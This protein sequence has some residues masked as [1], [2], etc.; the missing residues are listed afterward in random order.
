MPIGLY[1]YFNMNIKKRLSEKLKDKIPSTS[2]PIKFKPVPHNILL[3]SLKSSIISNE[4]AYNYLTKGN[5]IISLKKKMKIQLRFNTPYP[6]RSIYRW[7]L[8]KD[9]VE[10]ALID[11]VLFNLPTYTTEDEVMVSGV[12]TKKC[13]I[14]CDATQVIIRIDEKNDTIVAEIK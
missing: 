14:T 7:S 12:L 3:N 11:D 1:K 2:K 8:L 9:G 10:I 13:H 6:E 5:D 4:E